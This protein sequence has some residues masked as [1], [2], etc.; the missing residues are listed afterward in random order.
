MTKLK[1]A[2]AIRSVNKYDKI[3]NIEQLTSSTKDFK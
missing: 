3:I 1:I 2:T